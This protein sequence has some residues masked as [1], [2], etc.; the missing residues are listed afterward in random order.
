M[1]RTVKT[2]SMLILDES[3]R[4]REF[5]AALRTRDRE[6]FDRLAAHSRRHFSAISNS[7]IINPFEAVI[8]SIL[9]E[10]EKRIESLEDDRN[11]IRLKPRGE[12]DSLM[13][14]NE[15]RDC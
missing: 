7:G 4:W 8:L 15:R 6:A 9:L 14:K 3:S 5:R 1:G 13:D 10:Y 12:P 2:A 11:I